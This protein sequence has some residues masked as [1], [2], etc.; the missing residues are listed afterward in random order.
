MDIK[1]PSLGFL[2]EES[3]KKR[4]MLVAACSLE[5]RVALRR[6]RVKKHFRTARQ[7]DSDTF[8]SRVRVTWTDVDC[9]I[10]VP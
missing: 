2:D 8:L 5:R 9:I 3:G 10:I 6:N 7:K 1:R 4:R